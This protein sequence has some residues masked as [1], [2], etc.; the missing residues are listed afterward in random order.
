M[1]GPLKTLRD[2]NRFPVEYKQL[3]KRNLE[4]VFLNDGFILFK[5]RRCRARGFL[6]VGH[7]RPHFPT[8]GEHP[9]G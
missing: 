5:W 8:K 6:P 4:I 7:R 9:R 3:L 2:G 1:F